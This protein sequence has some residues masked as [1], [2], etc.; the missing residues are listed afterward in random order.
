M[1]TTI[2]IS[3]ELKKELVKRKGHPRESYEEVI[4]KLVKE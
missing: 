1:K 3:E 4:W 2:A